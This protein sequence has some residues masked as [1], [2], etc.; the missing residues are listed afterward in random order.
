MSFQPTWRSKLN[1]VIN[2]DNASHVLIAQDVDSKGAKRFTTF[3]NHQLVLDYIQ[4]LPLE[5]R[6]LYEHFQYD[7]NKPTWNKPTKLTFDLEHEP[8]ITDTSLLDTIIM[9]IIEKTEKM[10]LELNVKGKLSFKLLDASTDTKSSFHLVSNL[11]FKTWKAQCDAVNKYF[12]ELFKPNSLML[13]GSIYTG[14]GRFF[15]MVGCNKYGKSNHLVPVGDDEPLLLHYLSTYIDET[16]LCCD[17][18][19]KELK[20][21]IKKD[22]V[23]TPTSQQTETLVNV[24]KSNIE[25]FK[26][27]IDD[28]SSWISLG[29]KF[30]RA[31]IPEQIFHEVS[32]LSNKYNE[33]ETHKKWNSFENYD[34]NVGPLVN[35]LKH[36][37]SIN[38]ELQ[39]DDTLQLTFD[40]E[41]YN[42][43]TY[44]L[45][46]VLK[47]VLQ[48]IIKY[49]EEKLF[50]FHKKWF[51]DD[52]HLTELSTI[53][54]EKFIPLL[55]EDLIKIHKYTSNKQNYIN[56]QFIEKLKNVE[57]S[58]HEMILKLQGGIPDFMKSAVFA[59]FKDKG[60]LKNMNAD[61]G[62]IGFENGYFN[63]AT[64]SFEQYTPEVLINMSTGYDYDPE[65][66]EC[67]ELD[68]FL[69]QVLPNASIRHYV[70]K[71][72]SANLMGGN[73]DDIIMFFT[74][75]DESE[76][77]GS[78]GKSTLLKLIKLVLG[79]YA[80]VG[81]ND[82]I[83]GKSEASQSANSAK[84]ALKHKRAAIFEEVELSKKDE[85]NMEKLKRM[86]G[87][88]EETGREF[89]GKQEK[90]TVTFSPI[91]AGNKLPDLSST[92]GGTR[93][94]IRRV[95]FES[96]FV[97]DINS[98]EYEGMNVFPIDLTMRD[99]MEDF[100][101]PM[102][103]KLI[104]YY[105][106]YYLTEGIGKDVTPEEI[107]ACTDKYVDNKDAELF[108]FLDNH[109]TLAGEN[110]YTK[111]PDIRTA[112]RHNIT[113]EYSMNELYA[114]LKKKY[115]GHYYEQK[116]IN[117]KNVKNVIV[118]YKIQ[119]N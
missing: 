60:F 104:Y 20:K 109:V 7:K 13:D 63:L 87:G 76:Q 95:P 116:K 6:C 12:V 27:H 29:I 16:C 38:V 74:G 41:D 79:Q 92:D 113:K 42:A 19:P 69:E 66:K 68:T 89:Y 10:A 22:I 80:T 44:K 54:I 33:E 93:R 43:L 99:R 91:I 45:A 21:E 78:N 96:K 59:S 62:L 114:I 117:G 39:S 100:V 107:Q 51:Q 52:K 1:E 65:D 106:T 111:L 11:F 118:G 85:I 4:T 82:I 73:R 105:Y 83:T 110:E 64:H 25:S 58:I 77:T 108:E 84:M 36:Q 53:V 24:I 30:Y 37:L 119:L 8:K 15:R 23:F 50:I 94:R 57:A 32:R 9:C 88:C 55:E 31:D 72:L 115:K 26:E 101:M 67:P 3:P 90:F 56:E 75:V 5:D 49:D 98:S 81:A 47:Q 34:K 86:S 46:S 112:T 71:Y 103:N 28:Y 102:M 18:K 48:E 35:F 2:H 17:F 70:L 40:L 14:K 61:L 97:H